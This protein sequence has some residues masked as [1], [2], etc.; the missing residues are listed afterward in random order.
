VSKE[1]HK[2]NL[3]SVTEVNGAGVQSEVWRECTKC[4]AT[5][6]GFQYVE[7]CGQGQYLITPHVSGV[8]LEGAVSDE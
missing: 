5:D 2:W 4:G 6:D 1:R 8:S 3:H 7:P